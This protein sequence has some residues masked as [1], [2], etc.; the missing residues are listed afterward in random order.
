MPTP[1]TPSSWNAFLAT[2]AL[3]WAAVGALSTAVSVGVLIWYTRVTSRLLQVSKA[4]NQ[5]FVTLTF[6]R[7]NLNKTHASLYVRNVGASPALHVLV[8]LRAPSGGALPKDVS[9]ELRRDLLSAHGGQSELV[10]WF[11]ISELAGVRCE[12]SFRDSAGAKHDAP[13]ALICDPQEESF[14]RWDF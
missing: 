12:V 13:A 11:P 3:I 5:P 2:P 10:S 8:R 9:T 6:D 1:D 14:F 7:F 4:A